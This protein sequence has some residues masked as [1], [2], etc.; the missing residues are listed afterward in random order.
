MTAEGQVQCS[1]QS[2][3][4]LDGDLRSCVD[5]NEC[6]DF[7]NGGCEQLCAN[8]PGGFKC[9]CREGYK[10]RTD[11]P[12]KCQPVCDPPCNNYGVCVAPNSCDCPPG[13]P[14][15]GCSAMCSPPC[16]HGGTCMRWNKCLCPL[17][18][19]GAGCHTAICELPC[20]N[21]GRCVGPNIC[22]C[23][24]DYSGPQC[25]LP[26]CTPAC[27]NGGRC[28]DVNKCT[29][30]G[31]WQGARCQIE[32]IQCQKPCRNGGVCVGFNRCR[33]VKGFTGEVCETAVTTPCVP[34]CQHGA[35]CSPHNTCTCPEGTA[36]LRCERLTCPVLTTV[37][38]MDRAV[39]KAFRESYVDRCGP[40]GV[41]LCTKY[42]INQVRVY[43]QAYRLAET[44]GNVFSIQLGQEWMVVL[45]GPTILKE[46]LVNQGDS[47]ADRP[48]LQLIIDSCH[49]LGLGFSSGHL[50]KQQRQFAISTL[51]YFG[52]GSKSLEPVVLEEFTHCAKQFSEFK[53]TENVGAV[54]E[55]IS[56]ERFE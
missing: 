7:T 46:A 44:Y 11:D 23:P 9:T 5:V 36:G 33:C 2:G 34:P 22:Q 49:G 51:R 8:H 4:K 15:P 30:V 18:W 21:G 52:S 48:N 43:L 54:C 41:Q 26:L 6:G 56:D 1:C 27:Q 32:P 42:R 13:Y 14:G 20:A 17:G 35:T 19:T 55:L 25:L 50:W 31:G 47:V 12:T 10:V 40:L 28:V 45:N 38:S 37:V 3:W 24:S 16:A 53:A 39:R 29:C